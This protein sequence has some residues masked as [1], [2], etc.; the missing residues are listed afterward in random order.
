MPRALRLALLLAL[1]ASPLLLVRAQDDEEDLSGGDDM[2]EGMNDDGEPPAP[3]EEEEEDANVDESDV[4]V[5]DD[6]T[7]AGAIKD[8]KFILVEF[9]APWCGHCKSLKPEYARAATALKAAD[10]PVVLAKVDATKHEKGAQEYGVE[11]FPTLKFFV[12][13]EALEYSGGRVEAEIIEWCKKR[14]GVPTDKVETVADLDKV[15]ADRK[16]A[17]VGFFS[18]ES[19]ALF[20]AFRKAAIQVD[21]AMLEASAA[22]TSAKGASDNS[23][24]LYKSFDEGENKYTGGAN[25]TEIMAFISAN[26]RPSLFEFKEEFIEDMFHN[27]LPKIALFTY[28]AASEETM[29]KAAVHESIK[30]QFIMMKVGNNEDP[31]FFEYM[32]ID[33]NGTTPLIMGIDANSGKKFK[34]DAPYT[35]DSIVAFGKGMVDG[36][37][38][39]FLKSAPVPES[40]DGPVIEVVGTTFEEL[41]KKSTKNV[42]I[43]FYAPWC[44]HC[45]QLAPRYE[46][47]AKHFKETN[48]DDVVIAKI[49]GVANEIEEELPVEGFPSIFAKKAGTDEFVD[50]SQKPRKTTKALIN[51]IAK[52]FG[53]DTSRPGENR[54]RDAVA[55]LK[56]ALKAK[57]DLLEFVAGELEKAANEA[58]AKVKADPKVKDE[59]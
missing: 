24:V 53:I 25:A 32:G 28:D 54:Y 9:Y 13:G 31:N 51:S 48:P 7:L 21:K 30:G 4:L 55:R 11:G 5:L 6:N 37:V 57:P 29:A 58:E 8:N 52:V 46:E 43:E 33:P 19:G 2:P 36:T 38:K 17:V 45:Q 14:S 50:I 42:V 10:P 26:S 39:S 41:I 15:L 40:N 47:A 1:L 34:L 56:K 16:V 23:I 35:V 27:D 3:D 49:D 20:E 18:S 22:V 59:L 12:D 44:G